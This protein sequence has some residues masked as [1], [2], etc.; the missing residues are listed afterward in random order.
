M[1]LIEDFGLVSLYRGS[2]DEAI[3]SYKGEYLTLKPS[4]FFKFD[5]SFTWNP[6]I[7]DI[8]EDPN[9][10]NDG[11]ILMLRASNGSGSSKRDALEWEALSFSRQDG[12]FIGAYD[13]QGKFR[14]GGGGDYEYQLSGDQLGA[15]VGDIYLERSYKPANKNLLIDAIDLWISNETKASS[16][17]GDIND[18]TLVHIAS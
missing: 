8:F 10:S 11:N 15:I 9:S 1:E 2:N 13:V 3:V 17:Y 16:L 7:V 6:V 4:N 14:N 18:F 12:Y 5:Y